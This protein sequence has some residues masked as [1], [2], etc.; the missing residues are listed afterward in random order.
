MSKRKPLE[1]KIAPQIFWHVNDEHALFEWIAK[2]KCVKKI[3]AYYLTIRSKRISREDLWN[4]TGIFRR[5]NFE[6]IE[7]LNVFRNEYTE[8]IFDRHGI[9]DTRI[10]KD[11]GANSDISKEDTEAGGKYE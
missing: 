11:S 2:I 10:E 9:T 6:D 1:I 7:Q 5:Y 8:C 4:L 3:E